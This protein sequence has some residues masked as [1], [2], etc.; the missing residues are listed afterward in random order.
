MT[1]PKGPVYVCFDAELQEARYDGG[2]PVPDVRRFQPPAS[3]R[4]DLDATE[5]AADLLIEAREPVVLADL[6][7]RNPGA[8]PHL[9][10]LANLLGVQKAGI[11]T[12][13]DDPPA[14]FAKLAQAYGVSGF[15]PVEQPGELK[16]ALEAA[17]KIIREKRCAAL[18]DVVAQPR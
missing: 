14:D 13:I 4:A 15:G 3:M 17:L 6:F 8:V 1:E 16:G 5:A 12:R 2:C 7:G 10:D 11:G 18:V 9:E